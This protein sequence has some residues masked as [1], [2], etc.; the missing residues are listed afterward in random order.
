MPKHI[1]YQ[2]SV[3][4][5]ERLAVEFIAKLAQKIPEDQLAT[6][7][8]NKS[9]WVEYGEAAGI[10]EKEFRRGLYAFEIWRKRLLNKPSVQRASRLILW[11]DGALER[12]LGWRP[13][14]HKS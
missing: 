13:N 10:P 4:E 14:G 3:T 8:A 9:A 2:A 5:T 6:L 7:H 12:R 11:S 1:L